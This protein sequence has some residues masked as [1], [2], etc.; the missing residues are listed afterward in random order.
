MAEGQLFDFLHPARYPD[1]PARYRVQQ[2]FKGTRETLR[3][4]RAA[5][6]VAPHQQ[7]QLRRLGAEPRPVL[8]IWGRHDRAAP[9]VESKALLATMPRAA[10][11]PVDSAAH[12]PHLEQPGVVAQAVVRFLRTAPARR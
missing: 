9:F 8:I 11:V 6:A 2:R 1:W 7:E 3:R 12:L 10:F 4:T 5:I